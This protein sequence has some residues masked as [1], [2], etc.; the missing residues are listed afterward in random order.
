MASTETVSELHAILNGHY[1]TFFGHSN[2][3]LQ[4]LKTASQ[5]L[6]NIMLPGVA[7]DSI[8]DQ[9]GLVAYVV[10]ITVFVCY[11]DLIELQCGDL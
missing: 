11:S 7:W 3:Y 5:N 8:S 6:E 10:I 9:S 4:R 1:S 2:L